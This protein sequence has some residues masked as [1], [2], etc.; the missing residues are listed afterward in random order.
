MSHNYTKNLC[1]EFSRLE[2]DPRKTEKIFDLYGMSSVRP[3]IKALGH[4]I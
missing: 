2:V 1:T 3:R 4:D